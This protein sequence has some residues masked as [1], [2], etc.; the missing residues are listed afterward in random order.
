M[1]SG[2]A[3]IF[4]AAPGGLLTLSLLVASLV[5]VGDNGRLAMRLATTAR[6]FRADGLYPP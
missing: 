3:R 4:L 2:Y 1:G 5:L 6:Q